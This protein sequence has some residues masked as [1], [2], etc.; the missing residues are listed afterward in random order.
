MNSRTE[1]PHE[2]L[3]ALFGRTF[4]SLK[5]LFERHVAL[6]KAELAKDTKG[7]STD[8]LLLA[9]GGV[10]LLV[11]YVVLNVAIAL[12][13]SEWLGRAGGFVAV[14]L[15][16]VLAGGGAVWAGLSRL[17]N[18]HLLDDTRAQLKVSAQQLAISFK[19]ADGMDEVSHGR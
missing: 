5:E 7:L 17:R 1:T 14:G 9:G 8:V 3:T 15:F 10:A 13:L 2:S 19:S 11:G 18:R 6:A 12:G 4:E 16:N